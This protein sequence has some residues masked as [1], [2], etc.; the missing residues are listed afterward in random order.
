MRNGRRLYFKRL[1]DAKESDGKGY[2]GYVQSGEY[3][4]V[5]SYGV[6]GGWKRA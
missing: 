2:G 4:G 1:V 6:K 3:D 5:S